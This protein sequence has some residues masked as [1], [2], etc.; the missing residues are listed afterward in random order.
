MQR[1]TMVNLAFG[2]LRQKVCKFKAFLGW[3]ERQSQENTRKP[4]NLILAL[5][6]SI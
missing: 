2:R 4:I 1:F 3:I 5:P 6:K